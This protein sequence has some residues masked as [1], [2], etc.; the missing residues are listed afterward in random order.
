MRINLPVTQREH[1]L[2]PGTTLLSVTDCE[3]RILFANQAF[4]DAS[5][6]TRE[7]LVGQPHNIVRHPDMPAEAFRDMWATI[8]AGRP[9]SA[10]VKNRRKSGDHYWVRANAT[11][12]KAGGRLVGYLSARTVPTRD[13]VA[14]AEALY[15]AMRERA[16]AGST[17]LGL[18]GARPVRRDPL[19]R[20]LQATRALPRQIGA[21]GALWLG[22][23][24]VSA[25]AT[26]ALPG[27]AGWGITAGIAAAALVG[28]RRLEQRALR[29]EIEQALALAAGDLATEVEWTD[30]GTKG[31]L[32]L[33]LR[34]LAVNL[35]TAVS[36]VRSDAQ[37]LRGAVAEI[38]A[39][40]QDLSARTE[41]QASSLEQTAA[42]MEQ[43]NGTVQQSAQSAEQGARLAAEATQVAERSRDGVLSVVQAMEQISESS[44]RIGEII[45]VIEGVAFQTNIL[46]LN[47]AVEAARAGEQ[48][49]GFAVVASEVRSLAQRTT[50][51]AREIKQLIAESTE[52][53]AAGQAQTTAARDRM[54]E[55]LQ[56]VGRMST[57]L[58]E[59]GTAASEQRMGVGQVNEA[60]TH[61]DSITQQNAAM[62]EELAA[63]AQAL[64]VQAQA[65]DRG[66]GLFSLRAGDRDH[67]GGVMSASPRAAAPAPAPTARAVFEPKDAIAAHMQWKA[68]LRNA[69]LAG[70]A[71]DAEKVGCDDACPL[72]QWLHGEGRA[73]WGRRPRFT[74]LVERHAAFHRAA[75]AVARVSNAGRRE[76]ALAMLEGGTPFAQATQATVMAIRAL[77][78][79][80]DAPQPVRAATAVTRPTGVDRP[81][82]APTP[83]GAAR[84][85]ALASADDADWQ[86]F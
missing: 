8:Q 61:L 17:T 14:A 84:E 80:I 5:G 49:R 34:Q 65:V 60:V 40:N 57:L 13:E 55:A 72:G 24:A 76:E 45:G 73:R 44:R 20:V 23:T 74:E 7:E 83:V 4:V 67:A 66:L 1:L 46:A 70:E 10:L 33:V 32:Q 25:A 11:P 43:I 81:A 78:V 77:Q 41:S 63:A 12:M 22:A 21:S 53:V 31:D 3:S 51:A 68:R 39:G 86:S 48:G 35:R 85:T 42:S 27:A 29:P 47:A 26:Q 50:D 82:A 54:Q 36:D 52:R 71:L 56:V 79:D 64:A 62:V 18:S 75:A 2:E 16:A 69:A 30:D 6:Y 19:G 37:A 28:A 59:I 38:A 15:A 58:A 9:W